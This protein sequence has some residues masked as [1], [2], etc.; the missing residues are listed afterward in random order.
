MQLK[1]LNSSN[2]H[3]PGEDPINFVLSGGACPLLVK[4][5]ASDVNFPLTR[6]GDSSSAEIEIS[7]ESSMLSLK[8]QFNEKAHY[9]CVP[10]SGKL[11]PLEKTNVT[12]V[13][14][15]RQFG[16]HKQDLICTL[17]SDRENSKR[18]KSP[19]LEDGEIIFKLHGTTLNEAAE[20]KSQTPLH[21]NPNEFTV[22][23][24]LSI[25]G[26]KGKELLDGSLG[27]NALL[28]NFSRDSKVRNR[29]RYIDYIRESHNKKVQNAH[30]QYFSNDGVQVD[31]IKT[32]SFRKYTRIDPGS[33]LIE[34]PIDVDFDK[35]I[36]STKEK[37]NQS[38]K[39]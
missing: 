15:P 24:K 35:N 13:F 18:Q 9:F 32:S 39:F 11:M 34:P 8:Y 1:I 10:S 19:N 37:G 31:P 17:R 5:S 6:V 21:Y 2:I 7:N 26:A 20:K 28:E 29:N 33:G 12:V 16:I 38:V 22:V 25:P 3:R 4:H 14:K 23:K 30:A 27:Y 36:V